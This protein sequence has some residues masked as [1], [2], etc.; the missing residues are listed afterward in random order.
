MTAQ[1]G[2]SPASTPTPAALTGS[3]SGQLNYPA[4]SLPPLN[5]VAYQVG[6]SNYGIITPHAGQ[7][8]YQIDDLTPGTYHVVAYT[9]GGGGFPTGLAGGYTQA[10]PGG[11][12]V[13]CTDH[14]LIDVTGTGGANASGADPADW[15]A[16]E[17]TFPPFPASSPA[18][19]CAATLPPAVADGSIAA[20]LTYPA[21]ACPAMADV[22]RPV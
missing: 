3:I 11:F 7:G 22:V 19:T 8:T 15:N 9:V 18:A 4:E 13:R 14:T 1:A 20:T 5:V 2:G 17:G 21:D 6:T 16:P 12:R 10:G